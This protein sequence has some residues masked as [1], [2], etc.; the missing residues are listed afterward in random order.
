M[1]SFS[2]SDAQR[3][4]HESRTGILSGFP[5]PDEL[6]RLSH[7]IEL[8]GLTPAVLGYRRFRLILSRC[9]AAAVR[10]APLDFRHASIFAQRERV[11]YEFRFA[12][13]LAATRF[14]LAFDE[15]V[16][17]QSCLTPQVQQ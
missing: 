7:T 1:T 14:R 3:R 13:P 15:A 10:I 16:Q 9:I 4:R 12:N 6:A 8:D 2:L 11:G 5:T 17:D